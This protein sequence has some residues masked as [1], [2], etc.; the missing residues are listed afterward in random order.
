MSPSST[1]R[2]PPPE[3]RYPPGAP[4]K[5]IPPGRL[6]RDRARSPAARLASVAFIFSRRCGSSATDGRH[7]GPVY[8]FTPRSLE[9]PIGLGLRRIWRG[10]CFWRGEILGGGRRYV[11][12]LARVAAPPAVLSSAPAW[13]PLNLRRAASVVPRAQESWPCIFI[14]NWHVLRFERCTLRL[15]PRTG[16]SGGVYIPSIVCPPRSACFD[17]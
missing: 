11:A 7:A 15:F 5:A 14:W 12:R 4:C 13:H 2:A 3:L 8:V 1:Q 17:F 10:G 6:P 16:L 9:E